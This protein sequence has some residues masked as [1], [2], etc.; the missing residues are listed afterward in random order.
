M[1][2]KEIV[3][4]RGPDCLW[5]DDIISLLARIGRKHIALKGSENEMAK[6]VAK[7]LCQ[8]KQSCLLI[9]GKPV[10][11]PDQNRICDE[12]LDD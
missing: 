4:L 8:D 1:K 7:K 9:N 3:L 10:D 5:C 6:A 11:N 2:E 12:V